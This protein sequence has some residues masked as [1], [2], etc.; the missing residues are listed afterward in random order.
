M[1]SETPYR[2]LIPFSPFDSAL[3]DA[4]MLIM[5]KSGGG[6]AVSTRSCFPLVYFTVESDASVMKVR[7]LQLSAR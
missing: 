2:Q 3:S 1:L 5:A 6:K 7:Y 4:N